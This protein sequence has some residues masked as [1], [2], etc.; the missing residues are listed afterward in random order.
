MKSSF[1]RLQ[2]TVRLVG[3]EALA[4]PLRTVADLLARNPQGL[5]LAVYGLAGALGLVAGAKGIAAVGSLAGKLGNAFFGAKGAAPALPGP[6]GLGGGIGAPLPV[7]VT[8]MAPGGLGPGGL[9]PSGQPAASPAAKRGLRSLLPSKGRLVGGAVAGAAISAAVAVPRMVSG[10]RD[11]REREGLTDRERRAAKGGEIGE[12]VGSVAGSA[13]GGAAGIAAG[14]VAAKAGAAAGAKIGGA[15][16]SVVPVVGNIV[17]LALGGAIGAGVGLLGAR[18]GRAVGEGVGGAGRATPYAARQRQ[19]AARAE[20]NGRGGAAETPPY[21]AWQSPAPAMRGGD[22]LREAATAS[23][24]FPAARAVVDGEIRLES[25]L[26]VDGGAL[27]L[28]QEVA[29]NTTPYRFATGA[30]AEARM[31]Q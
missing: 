2:E 29:R 7:F 14:A 25:R 30:A 11:V 28:R 15:L 9:G 12:A 19:A 10:L 3:D 23:A 21:S 31:I 1:V 5:R 26:S 18:A 4:G 6:G 8:N 27:V 16:G 24:S 13:A 17:G 20:R 22:A